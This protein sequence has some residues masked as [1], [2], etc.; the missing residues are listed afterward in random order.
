M[1][2]AADDVGAAVGGLSLL[3][4]TAHPCCCCCCR[5]KPC[6]LLVVPCL[7]V[8]STS[9]AL[10]EA[11]AAS[12]MRQRETAGAAADSNIAAMLSNRLH[13]HHHHSHT[14]DRGSQQQGSLLPPKQQQQ[15]QYRWSG[16]VDED[17][18]AEEL[19][20]VWGVDDSMA[21]D[22][23]EPLST[24]WRSHLQ[25]QQQVELPSLPGL[26]RPVGMSDEDW[27][28]VQAV[29]EQQERLLVKQQQ[30]QE[31]PEVD[32]QD[33]Q[34]AA[35]AAAGGAGEQCV[36]MGAGGLDQALSALGSGLEFIVVE[37]DG[38]SRVC[39][40]LSSTSSPSSSDD[41]EGGAVMGSREYGAGKV[42]EG[43]VKAAAMVAVGGSSRGAVLSASFDAAARDHPVVLH[44]MQTMDES[45]LHG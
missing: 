24:W 36:L 38:I 33:P 35:A 44:S 4:C 10:A 39:L 5:A 13:T 28:L 41:E 3:V 42:V 15:Q 21:D 9:Q 27:S 12:K 29:A 19:S 37:Q 30:Q 22:D 11:F 20:S 8:I 7:Q 17:W 18:Q 26:L 32:L 14:H 45:V 34:T 25:Q 40:V 1:H 16:S 2:E 31:G 6:F 43:L 23:D